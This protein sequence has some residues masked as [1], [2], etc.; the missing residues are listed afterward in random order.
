MAGGLATLAPLTSKDYETLEEKGAK[1]E[2]GLR[3]KSLRVQRV[4]SMMTVFFRSEPVTNLEDAQGCEP[5]RFARW[6][7]QMLDR[8]V[9]L[10]PSQFEAFFVSLAHTDEDLDH[11]INAHEAAKEAMA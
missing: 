7:K 3:H 4:G 8:G 10:P 1:L 2:A 5:D 9:Y 11:V 6:H